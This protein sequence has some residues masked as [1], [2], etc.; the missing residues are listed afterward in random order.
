MWAAQIAVFGLSGLAAFLLRFDF[1]LPPEY[2]RHLAYA[3][4]VWVGVKIMVFRVAKLD[5]GW[6]RYVS[7][8]DLLWLVLGNIV[9]SIV[10]CV[11]ILSIGPPGLPRSIYLLDLMICFLGTAGARMIVRM[12]V[13][14]TANERTGTLAKNTLIYGAGEAGISLLREIQRNSKLPYRVR[15]FLD[16]RPD[17]KGARILG[18]PVLGGGDQLNKRITKNKRSTPF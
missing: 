16:D 11:V 4:P 12:A 6:W 3:I 13:E 17:K 18:V 15:G 9:G 8:T 10:S 1:G 2:M 5:R 14:A 7:I